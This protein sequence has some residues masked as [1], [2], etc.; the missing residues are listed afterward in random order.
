MFLVTASK[1]RQLLLLSFSGVVTPAELARSRQ[2]LA[3]ILAELPAGIRVLADFTA[4]ESMDVACAPEIGRTMELMEQKGISLVV[5]VIPDPAKD[6]GMKMLS[7]FH[8]PRQ[9]RSVTC[10]TMAEGRMHL[11]P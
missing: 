11:L 2:E 10:A 3:D 6:I 4:L 1:P 9:P 7:L 8:Y 5:R